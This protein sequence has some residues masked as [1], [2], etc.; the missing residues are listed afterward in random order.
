MSFQDLS[1]AFLFTRSWWWH[2]GGEKYSIL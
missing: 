2:S 1:A